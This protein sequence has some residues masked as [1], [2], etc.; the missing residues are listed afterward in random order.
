M[1]FKENLNF[2]KLKNLPGQVTAD[3][4]YNVLFFR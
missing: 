2:N 1:Q 3:E 4:K